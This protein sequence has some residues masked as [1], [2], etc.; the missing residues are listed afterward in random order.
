MS[1]FVLLFFLF[2]TKSVWAQTPPL[3]QMPKQEFFK[4]TVEQ[5]VESG[6]KEIEKNKYYY[7]TLRVKLE[8]GKFTVIE[9]GKDFQI[10]KDQLVS[11]GEKI[12][13]T[14]NTSPS[15]K[16]S[17]SLYETYRLTN[18]IWVCIIFFLMI[19]II[20]GIKG[21]GS[22]MGMIISLGIIALYIIP[23]IL[24]GS[25][26]LTT[27]LIGSVVILILSGYIAHGISKKTTIALTSTLISLFIT[28]IFS[29]L[30]INFLK[31]AG[32]GTEDAVA[33]Q[34]G[35]TS[36][37]DLKGLFLS[38][39]I[40]GTL[41]ALNDVTTTQSA[42]IF[43]LKMANPKYKLL[44]LFEKGMSIGKE[45]AA[46]LVN[47]LILAYAGSAFAVFIFLIVNPAHVPYWV[48]LNNEIIADEI[49]KAILGSTGLILSV[50][51]VTLLASYFFSK[52]KI[53]D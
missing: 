24:K 14:K 18:L 22:I 36:F 31:I 15:G 2:F 38:G 17:Y 13:V 33:L 28:F 6:T 53:T 19:L 16:I 50:P 37:I 1:I 29:Q 44:T 11:K 47:T 4:A 41:G 20:S 52:I 30:A 34:I 23:Q 3:M 9:N 25:D 26:P 43:E 32:V 5:V 40:I 7:Q 49:T 46:S 39:V 12:V 51:I 21:L 35:R 42:A 48:I 10:T 27:T 45:H 8:N